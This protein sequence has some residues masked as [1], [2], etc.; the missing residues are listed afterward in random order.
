MSRTSLHV[1]AVA[2]VLAIAGCG[3]GR[4]PQLKVLSVERATTAPRDL[5]LFVE[6]M[7]PAARPLELERLQYRFERS[8]HVAGVAPVIGEVL[9]SRTVDAGAAVVVEVPLPDDASLPRGE[10]LLLA[11]R[12]F[13]TQDQLRRS[14]DVRATVVR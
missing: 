7:N 8:V 11:G 4:Q 2:L 5:V 9:L 13:A 3:A 12:L 1:A 10:A 14:F 6:V